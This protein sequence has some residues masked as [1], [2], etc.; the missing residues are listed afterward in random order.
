MLTLK[1]KVN[2]KFMWFDSQ[3]ITI[4]LSLVFYC[5]FQL[6]YPHSKEN[7]YKIRIRRITQRIQ[8][9]L[10]SYK[11]RIDRQTSKPLENHTTHCTCSTKT[12]RT[13]PSPPTSIHPVSHWL[14]LAVDPK[15]HVEIKTPQCFASLRRT[16]ED[17]VPPGRPPVPRSR[18]PGQHHSP[19]PS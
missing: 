11:Y 8:R 19:E 3:I 1:Q 4:C 18:Q 16:L 10:P 12:Y 7:E 5:K 14:C 9:L 13:L 6:R 15:P 17:D 2:K